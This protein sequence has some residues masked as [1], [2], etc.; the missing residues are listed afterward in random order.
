VVIR[1]NGNYLVLSP[2]RMKIKSS[3]PK[4][5]GIY[6]ISAIDRDE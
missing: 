3:C 1:L 6:L 5:E 2:S 4:Y